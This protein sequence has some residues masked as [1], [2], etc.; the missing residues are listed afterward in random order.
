MYFAD[1]T[2]YTYLGNDPSS[3]KS[4]LNVGW[5]DD[6]HEFPRGDVPEEALAKI[7]ELCRNPVQKTRG[8]HSCQLCSERRWGCIAVRSGT[9]LGIGSGEIRVKGTAGV[10]Y[11]SPCMIYHYISEHHYKPPQQFIEAVLGLGG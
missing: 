2:A 1:L 5:L 10:T 9:E 4:V 8:A 6:Q 7:F 3:Q 11:A